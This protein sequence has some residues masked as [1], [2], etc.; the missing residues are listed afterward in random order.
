MDEARVDYWWLKSSWDQEYLKNSILVFTM[1][2]THLDS[3]WSLPSS[4][5]PPLSTL[6]ILLAQTP[7]YPTADVAVFAK[8][9]FAPKIFLY[10]GWDMSHISTNA[11]TRGNLSTKFI[12]C[13]SKA[14]SHRTLIGWLF[15]ISDPSL[16][17]QKWLL[18]QTHKDPHIMLLTTIRNWILS[19]S[20][21]K[22]K[23]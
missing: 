19:N 4:Q 14:V 8:Y 7:D 18:I 11:K 12:S 3:I 5:I 13:A 15:F 20:H 9:I 16:I 17:A 22:A 6:D 10:H 1:T 23:F 21:Q 2:F